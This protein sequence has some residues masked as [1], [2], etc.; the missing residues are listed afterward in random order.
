MTEG[1]WVRLYGRGFDFNSLILTSFSRGGDF[2]FL[3]TDARSPG[4]GFES[5]EYGGGFSIGLSR[6]GGGFDVVAG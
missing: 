3:G 2:L 1:E 5:E 4:V 6:I